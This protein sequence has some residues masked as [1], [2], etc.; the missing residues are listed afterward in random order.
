MCVCV[1]LWIDQSNNVVIL[2]TI[3]YINN[4]W[5]CSKFLTMW[6][7]FHAQT[8]SITAYLSYATFYNKKTHR[9]SRATL[10]YNDVWCSTSVNMSPFNDELDFFSKCCSGQQ[11]LNHYE[12]QCLSW[13][14]RYRYN[15]DLI[16]VWHGRWRTQQTIIFLIQNTIRS[17]GKPGCDFH[18]SAANFRIR[19]LNKFS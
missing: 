8:R 15:I 13:Q 14:G 18:T 12:N 2:V 5:A 1:V 10:H 11:K 4:A 16:Y 19:L 3:Q 6:I 7:S 9:Q 17:T